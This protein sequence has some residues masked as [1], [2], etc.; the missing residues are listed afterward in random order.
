M[1]EATEM[2]LDF[3]QMPAGAVKVSMIG[4]NEAVASIG[5]SSV[6]V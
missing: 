4:R 1:R 5:A 2:S 6:R 3:T